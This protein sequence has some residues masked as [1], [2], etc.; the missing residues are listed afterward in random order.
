MLAARAFLAREEEEASMRDGEAA[1]VSARERGLPGACSSWRAR[2]RAPKQLRW[3]R[4]GRV[5]SQ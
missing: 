4:R 3:S 1:V 5:H 2:L